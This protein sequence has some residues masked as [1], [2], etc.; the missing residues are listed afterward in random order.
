M[1]KIKTVTMKN[2]MS[3]GAVTQAVNLEENGLTLILGDNLDLGSNGSRNGVGKTVLLHAI[4]YGIFGAPLTNIKKDNLINK[5]NQKN[6]MVTVEFEKDGHS[7]RIERGRR[8]VHFKYIVDNAVVNESNTDEAQGDMRDT[9]KLLL[10]TIGCTH[11]LFKHIAAMSTKTIPFLSE[12]ANVQREIIEELLGIT[13]L[14]EKADRLK[15]LIKYTKQN[16]EKEEVKLSVIQQQND[17]THKTIEEMER[18]SVFWENNHKKKIDELTRKIQELQEVDIEEEIQ[19]H[20]LVDNY[21]ILEQQLASDNSSLKKEKRYLDSLQTQIDRAENNLETLKEKKC[22]TCGQELHD[23]KHQEL[24]ERSEAELLEL[25]ENS[26]AYRESVDN[27]TA[28]IQEYQSAIDLMGERPQPF[29][30]TANEAY[31]HR[32]NLNNMIENLKGLKETLNPNLENIEMMRNQNLTELNYTDLNQLNEIREHQEFILKI[33]TDKKSWVRMQII[34]Q[35][36]GY[37]NNR[38]AIY[39]NKLGLPHTVKFQSDLSVK[40]EKLGQDFDFDN[41]SNGESI[42]LILSLS[43]AFRDVFET[44]T[45]HMNFMFIDELIDSGVD[46]AGVEN[47]LGVLKHMTREQNKNVFLVSHKDDLISR[48]SNVLL[49]QKENN[50]T[51]YHYEQE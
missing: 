24:I 47:T 34:D 49:V 5:T 30:G 48:C 27:L 28:Q 7:Y 14:S 43:W 42:R 17:K 25:C 9:Q 33:L 6:M 37:L 1:F 38:L 12:K 23:H 45:H 4:S 46:T 13:Q 40:I 44:L 2:F 11:T 35:N 20:E 50:F 10:D 29:Y 3:I 39:L 19:K 22:S 51:S 26:V 41:L 8:P 18:K 31:E 21:R 36:L 32:S 15:E 16:I